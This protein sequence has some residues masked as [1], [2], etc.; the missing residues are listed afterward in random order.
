MRNWQGRVYR[1]PKKQK[2]KIDSKHWLSFR[3]RVFKRDKYQCQRC[4]QF[5]GENGLQLTAH[6]IIPR[7]RGRTVIKNLIT[8]CNSCHDFVEIN[9]FDFG[10]SNLKIET[11]SIDWHKWVYGGYKRPNR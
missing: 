8:L 4:E 9:G 3:K 1:L 6:H 7:P 10:N 2:L 5:Y 11:K